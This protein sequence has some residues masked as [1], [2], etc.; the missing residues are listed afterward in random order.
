MR[1]LSEGAGLARPIDLEEQITEPAEEGT[2]TL[3][4][5]GLSDTMLR[6]DGVALHAVGQTVR[7]P[8]LSQR[9]PALS[10]G[11]LFGCV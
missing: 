6:L 4:P 5:I 7:Q 9:V 2:V 8:A 3:H 1:G 10:G 11:P